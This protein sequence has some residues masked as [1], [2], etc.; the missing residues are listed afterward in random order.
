MTSR[1]LHPWKWICHLT[2]FENSWQI[3]LNCL[4]MFSLHV[5]CCRY[6]AFPLVI[7]CHFGLILSWYICS[8]QLYS[9]PYMITHSIMLCLCWV[10]TMSRCLEQRHMLRLSLSS[11]F[12]HMLKV[13]IWCTFSKCACLHHTHMQIIHIWM[14]S[15]SHV[16]YLPVD[17]GLN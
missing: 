6:D 14:R 1:S 2:F 12:L 8:F 5:V 15:Q 11:V 16:L 3:L 10:R 17:D 4:I 9:Y 13:S 7:C